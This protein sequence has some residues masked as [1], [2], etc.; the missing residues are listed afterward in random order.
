MEK[1]EKCGHCR[2]KSTS[3]P[4][5]NPFYFANEPNLAT[6]R[7]HRINSTLLLPDDFVFINVCGT[8]YQPLRSTLRRFPN[9]LLADD[10][11]MQRYYVE[12]MDSYYFDRHQESFDSILYYYQSGGEL[13]RPQSVPMDL[14]IRELTFFGIPNDEVI[15]LQKR[16]GYVPLSENDELQEI[17]PKNT[18]QRLVWQFIDHPESSI[19]ARCFAILTLLIIVVSITSFCMETIPKYHEVL[20][21]KE[22]HHHGSVHRNTTHTKNWSGRDA[23]VLTGVNTIQVIE[24]VSAYWFT[25]EY[26]IRFFSSPNKWKFFKSFM[27]LV[28]L[29]AILPFYIT[30]IIASEKGS[31]LAVIRVARLLRVFRVFKLSRHSKGLQVLGSAVRASINEL[32]MI[33]FLLGFGIVV[34]SSAMYYAEYDENEVSTFESIPNTFWYTL[35]TMTTVGYGDHVP[36]TLLG[37]ILGGLSSIMGVLTVAMVV[38]V[39]DTNFDFYYKRDRLLE[40]HQHRMRS[41]SINP[42]RHSYVMLPESHGS[43]RESRLKL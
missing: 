14:F 21:S 18:F 5:D 1:C 26:L 15:M 37:K 20:Y 34:F 19:W 43:R 40:A 16:E 10:R 28:D 11:Q 30:Q 36:Q 3:D 33:V 32:G 4:D 22:A 7:I 35:V 12:F 2:K 8:K 9:T 17:L 25:A 31:P 29:A 6:N 38:P 39:I 42:D 13:I 41:P 27:N 23:S 24:E